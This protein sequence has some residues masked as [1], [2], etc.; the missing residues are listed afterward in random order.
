MSFVNLFV[1][2]AKRVAAPSTSF[3]D[4]TKEIKAE[5]YFDSDGDFF[6]DLPTSTSTNTNK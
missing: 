5:S 1:G 4:M 6:E 2:I 3:I